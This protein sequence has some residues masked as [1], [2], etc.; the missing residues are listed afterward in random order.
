[1]IYITQ[2]VYLSPGKEA[3][4]NTFEDA[5]IPLISRHGGQLLLRLRPTLESVIAA[6]I[7]VPYEIHLVRFNS[8]E[9]LKAFSEDPERQRMLHLKNES[10]RSSVIVKGAQE[11]T[12]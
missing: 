11:G 10:V 6:E 9:D 2:L 8:Q 4:F 1:M 3:A 5:V 7:E 12:P